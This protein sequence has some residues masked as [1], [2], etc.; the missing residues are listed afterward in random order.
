MLIGRSS[1]NSMFSMPTGNPIWPPSQ[2]ID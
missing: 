1:T 2:Y